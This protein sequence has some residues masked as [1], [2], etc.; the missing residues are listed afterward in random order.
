MNGLVWAH[1]VAHARP[2]PISLCHHPVAEWLWRRLRHTFPRTA[3]AVLMPNHLHVL[4]ATSSPSRDRLR[5]ASLLGA[6]A[7]SA[8][9]LADVRF[10]RVPAPELVEGSEKLVR[11]VRYIALNPCRAR[12]ADDPLAWPWSTHRDVVGAIADPWVTRS[13]LARALGRSPE[14]VTRWIHRYVSSDPSVSVRGTPLP[15]APDRATLPTLPL[16]AAITAAAAATRSTEARARLRTPTRE[17]FLGLAQHSG[18]RDVV[19]LAQATGMTPRG[20]RRSL[21]RNAALS[22]DLLDDALRA[23]SLCLGDPRLRVIDVGH[24]APAG[25]SQAT[26]PRLDAHW[27]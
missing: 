12:L 6:M 21:R 1:F 24:V 11:M 23:G 10:D 25:L 5:L 19:L 27:A 18:W 3:A 4:A 15:A 7:R 16:G 13:G 26:R 9:P 14:G 2:G 22:D 8:P 20:V 17:L